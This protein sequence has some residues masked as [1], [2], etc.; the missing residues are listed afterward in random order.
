MRAKEKFKKYE[1]LWIKIRDLTGSV[2]K[3]PDDLVEKY[4]KIK[5]NSDGELHLNKTIE[6]LSMIVV[7]RAVFYEK[8]NIIHK[9]S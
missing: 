1:E 5:F 2:T 8:T 4:I 6:I 7:V 3:N 9:F